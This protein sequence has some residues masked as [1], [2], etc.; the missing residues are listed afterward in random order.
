[1]KRYLSTIALAALVLVGVLGIFAPA[2]AQAITPAPDDAEGLILA[3]YRAIADGSWFPAAG[4]ATLLL[5]LAARKLLLTRFPSLGSKTW[6]V[7]ILASLAGVGALGNAWL[8][9][10]SIDATTLIGAVKVFA[11]AVV[12]YF[13]GGKLL[14]SKQT[15]AAALLL[16]AAI[17]GGALAVGS[18]GCSHD[19]RGKTIHATLVA[20]DTAHAGFVAY[21]R[22]HQLDLVAKATTREEG[23]QALAEYRT[24]RD[25]LVVPKLVAVYRALAAAAIANDDQSLLSLLAAANQLHQALTALTGGKL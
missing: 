22:Q 3:A 6:G 14:A 13:V 9:D 1:M 18:A 25:E 5:L 16:V 11:T 7:A 23:A 19:A 15:G 10:A 4:A 24:R 20:T 8:A 21:D 12:G 17:G 2:F